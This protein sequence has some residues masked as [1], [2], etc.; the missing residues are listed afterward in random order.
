MALR[1]TGGLCSASLAVKSAKVETL[2]GVAVDSINTFDSPNVVVP[3]PTAVKVQGGK[4]IS[5][6]SARSVTV[7]SIEP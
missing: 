2:T 3:K 5:N 6:G 1:L 7:V 4:A